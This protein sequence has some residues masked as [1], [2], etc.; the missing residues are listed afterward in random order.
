MAGFHEF[1]YVLQDGNAWLQAVM[2]KVNTE[3]A[4]L[5]YTVLKATLHVLRDRIPPES[6]VHLGGPLP[7]A[8]RGV[9]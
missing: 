9:Y 4:H 3:D 8:I 7:T 6:A 2:K 5:V 1:D